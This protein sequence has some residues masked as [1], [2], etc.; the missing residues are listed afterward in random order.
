MRR[1]I[2]AALLFMAAE[3]VAQENGEME[4]VLTF[5]GAESPEEVDEEVVELLSHYFARPLNLNRASVSRMTESGLLDRYRAASLYDYRQ[6]HGDILS[7]AE[8]SMVDGFSED[9][10]KRLA[11]F[12]SMESSSLPGERPAA[13]RKFSCDLTVKA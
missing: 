3:C 9:I 1:L 7:L 5:L 8:L 12:I 10:V 13:G 2:I 4:A 11:P 6:R